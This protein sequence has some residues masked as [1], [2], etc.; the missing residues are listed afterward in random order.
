[1]PQGGSMSSRLQQQLPAMFALAHD[2][3]ESARIELAGKLADI[4]LSDGAHLSLREEELANELIDQLL[5][6][7]SPVL[8][9]QLVQKFADVAAMPRKIAM[10]LAC[11]SIDVAASILKNS[12][13]L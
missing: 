9:A 5:R 2:H 12:R 1:M 8:R 4:F 6:T 10:K 7:Q 3:S 13:T 11:D